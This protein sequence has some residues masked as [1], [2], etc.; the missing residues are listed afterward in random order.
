MGL[1]FGTIFGMMDLEE[2]PLRFIKSLLI[3]EENYSLPIGLICGGLAGLSVTIIDSTDGE[4]PTVRGEFKPLNQ[5][6][7]IEV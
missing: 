4:Q 1:V 3:K 6:D 7:E 2:A 5:E